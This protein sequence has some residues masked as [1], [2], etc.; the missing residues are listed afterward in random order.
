MRV[1]SSSRKYFNATVTANEFSEQKFR[2]AA[3]VLLRMRLL[4]LLRQ[5]PGAAP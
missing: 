2:E 1:L 5:S 3:F 4:G